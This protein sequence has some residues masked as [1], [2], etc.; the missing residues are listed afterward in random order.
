MGTKRRE[1]RD[2]VLDEFEKALQ[3]YVKKHPNAKLSLYRQ[4]PA[5]VRIRLIDPDLSSLS[6]VDRHELVWSYLE[7]LSD[8]TLSEL[9]ILLL[10]TPDETKK[11]IANMDFENPIPSLL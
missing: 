10:L 11:S 6:R 9:S 8:E 4:N 3:P 5:S 2:R 1:N 7:P